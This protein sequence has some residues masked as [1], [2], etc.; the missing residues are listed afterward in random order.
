MPEARKRFAR[1]ARA[2]AALDHPNICTVYE[3][4]EHEGL[5]FIAMAYLEGQ[6]LSA[7]LK[8][9]PVKVREGLSVGAVR[10]PAT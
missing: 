1:E 10:K 2:A 4:D 7:R 3:I 8:Q 9:E 6:T 5:T